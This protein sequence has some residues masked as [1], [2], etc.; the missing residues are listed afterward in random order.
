MSVDSDPSAVVSNYWDIY[1]S[2]KAIVF[3][4][5]PHRGSDAAKWL[6]MLSTI[7]SNVSGR[8]K[9]RFAELL[10]TH[11]N[12]LLEI[13]EDFMPL[14][15]SFSIVSFYEEYGEGWWGKVI[16]GKSSAV[17]GLPNEDDIMISGTHRSMCRFERGDKRFDAV[18]R[19]IRRASRGN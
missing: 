6:D 15:S 14:A 8:P 19:A 16:V 4:G 1:N 2:T 7:T 11:S 13:S 10:Q 9:S 12:G 18:W 3:F 5:T 17:M